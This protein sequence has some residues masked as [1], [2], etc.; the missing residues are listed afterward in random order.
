M[1][2]DPVPPPDPE[3]SAPATAR[4]AGAFDIRNFIGALIGIYGIILTIMGIVS[5]TASDI[6]KTGNVNANLIAGIC[7]VVF[8]V[9]FLVWAKL[10]PVVI[11]AHTDADEILR[12][13]EPGQ[14]H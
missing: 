6:E 12:E 13:H 7:M 9:I 4:S 11:P 2:A 10:R 8:A 1:S 5:F 14:G 3:G